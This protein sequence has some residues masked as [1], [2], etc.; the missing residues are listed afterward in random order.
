M[1]VH[2]S[3]VRNRRRMPSVN[4]PCGAC[5]HKRDQHQ[6]SAVFERVVCPRCPCRKY[7]RPADPSRWTPIKLTGKQYL[8][9]LDLSPRAA[10]PDALAALVPKVFRVG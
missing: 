4:L 1:T 9:T 10:E 6:W 3:T 5:G 8:D 7:R 2:R